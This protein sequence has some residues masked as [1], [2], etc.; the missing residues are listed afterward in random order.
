MPREG[1]GS[2]CRR[3]EL[4]KYIF[5]DIMKV[6][7]TIIRLPNMLYNDGIKSQDLWAETSCSF[8]KEKSKT[9]HDS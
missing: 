9:E 2:S 4:E 1:K 5:P 6:M 7:V 3:P 8:I